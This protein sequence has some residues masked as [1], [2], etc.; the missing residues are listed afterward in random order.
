MVR[1]CCSSASQISA[2]RAAASAVE[3]FGAGFFDPEYLASRR[4]QVRQMREEAGVTDD[5][6]PD[7]QDLWYI[8]DRTEVIDWFSAHGWEVSTIDAADLMKRYNRTTTTTQRPE[9]LSSRPG[10]MSPPGRLE[11]LRLFAGQ[12]KLDERA[13][14]FDGFAQR[15]Q[16]RRYRRRRQHRVTVG[17]PHR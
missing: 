7:V 8:E 3:S 14:G 13:D 9:R 5:D 11:A 4:E 1:I 2:P 12:L 17:L 10:E 15:R 16:P 6:T